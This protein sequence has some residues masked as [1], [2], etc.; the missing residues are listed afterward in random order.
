MP[1]LSTWAGRTWFSVT[2]LFRPPVLQAGR[3]LKRSIAQLHSGSFHSSLVLEHLTPSGLN[4]CGQLQAR[5]MPRLLECLPSLEGT[6]TLPKHYSASV[7]PLTVIHHQGERDDHDHQDRRELGRP[8][9]HQQK[10]KTPGTPE[11]PRD[12][13]RP[14]GDRQEPF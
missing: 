2:G 7:D 4:L 5:S 13:W 10:H 9:D 8:G 6:N 11:C 14:A 1:L 12:T 3:A